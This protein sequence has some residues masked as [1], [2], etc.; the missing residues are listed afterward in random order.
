MRAA[1]VIGGVLLLL[2]AWQPVQAQT[3]QPGTCETLVIPPNVDLN[4][5]FY[6]TTLEYVPHQQYADGQVGLWLDIYPV[7]G[8]YRRQYS[9][10]DDGDGVHRYTFVHHTDRVRIGTI[11]ARSGDIEICWGY[12]AT[13]TPTP[14]PTPAPTI[15][16]TITPI[17]TTPN[18]LPILPTITNPNA[19]DLLPE[20]SSAISESATGAGFP[21]LAALIWLIG[22][23]G[24]LWLVRR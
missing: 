23:F 6:G 17:P 24:L 10:D 21:L 12:P 16:A 3:P 1:V 20:H 4:V 18:P 8:S 14:T 9:R 5:D 19:L 7:N 13:P 15:T 11:Y 2:L 22:W